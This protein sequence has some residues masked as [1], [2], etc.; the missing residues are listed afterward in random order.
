MTRSKH[1]T[2]PERMAYTDDRNV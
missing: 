2:S 1:M